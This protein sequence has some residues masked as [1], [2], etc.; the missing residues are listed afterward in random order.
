MLHAAWTP[1]ETG[2]ASVEYRFEGEEWLVAPPTADG[3]AVLLGI[4]A[5]T[6]VEARVVVAGGGT[7]VPGA[8]TTATTGSLPKDLILPVVESWSPELAYD[9]DFV[10]ISV[11]GGS[12]TYMPPYWIEI[13]DRS[14]RV[15]W[16]K[17]ID[18][19]MMTFYP[20]VSLDGTHIW[21]EGSNIFGF[22]GSDPYV[23][24]RTLDGRWSET[25]TI[26]DMGQA[27][28]EGPEDGF[29]YEQRTNNTNGLGRIDAAG[30]TSTV[31]DCAAWMR[32]RNVR[33]ENCWMNTSN[34]SEER[35]T[36]LASMF[37]ADTV[38]EIDLAT[39][40]PIRQMGQLEVGEPYRFD[41]EE[42]TFAYQ[43]DVYWTDAGT[44][45]A[46]THVPDQSGVQVAAEYTVDDKT[47]TLTRIW[48]YTSTD[49]W[50]TQV[51]E[52]VR[53]PNGNTVQGYGQDGA[54]REVTS[55]G[56]I[57]WEVSWPEDDQGYRVVGHSS[58]IPDLYALNQGR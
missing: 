58:M 38:F 54:V 45:L 6:S 43:H 4:P 52:A 26:P 50:A 3:A 46:S 8:S 29:V 10:M 18:D 28:A 55:D 5:D 20:T 1:P 31:W 40:E 32:D 14:G 22:G 39:G 13:L 44:L 21:Y 34:W 51:G 37:E 15:V 27:V 11:S 19:Y 33:A 35:N 48:S 25:L 9:A 12:Y 57:A 53:L 17:Q 2:S 16:Y 42:S 24:R 49:R 56:T 7:E 41:P 47:R 30:T 23:V 36:V